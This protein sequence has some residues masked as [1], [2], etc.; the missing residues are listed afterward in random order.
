M[1][2]NIILGLLLISEVLFSQVSIN[3]ANPQGVFNIDAG[4][5]NPATGSA[6]TQAQQLNDVT[7]LGNGNV[8]I[9]TIT[10]TQ[11]FEI[12]TGGTA[13]VPVTG[14]KL[15]DGTQNDEYILTSDANGVGTWQLPGV[16][17]KMGAHLAHTFNI[18]FEHHGYDYWLSTG[19][20]ITLP[21]GVWKIE[22]T[23][24]LSGYTDDGTYLTSDD[25]MWCRFSL[26]SDPDAVTPG[27]N[28]TGTSE[29]I[30][31]PDFV[32]LD[33]SG[34]L[35]T[36]TP[37]YVSINYDGP[38]TATPTRYAVANGYFL[39]KNS[40]E[41]TYYIMANPA[42]SPTVD[43]T[44]FYFLDVG[45]SKWGENRILASSISLRN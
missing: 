45:S 24:L 15:A 21:A 44:G 8:G 29:T 28:P 4:R 31:T 26:S 7:V 42:L 30:L 5:D 1:K 36:G 10:P 22:V 6:H 2:K 12:Q 38:R 27:Y 9:G 25:W 18:P 43:K 32:T 20:Y 17:Y 13:A 35:V 33:T 39:I 11:K 3:T 19:S 23:E 41:T 34:N 16:V 40:A 37:Q 14:F